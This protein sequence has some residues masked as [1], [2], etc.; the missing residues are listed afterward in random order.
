MSRRTT[1]GESRGLTFSCEQL[2]L[3][4]KP[5]ALYEGTFTVYGQDGETWGYVESTDCRMELLNR[6]FAGVQDMVAFRFRGERTVP[7]EEISGSIRIYS[8][9]GEYEIPFQV[10]VQQTEIMSS[11]G[12]IRNLNQFAMLARN[13]WEE[14]VKLFYAPDFAELLKGNDR[15][16]LEYYRGLRARSGNQQNVEAFLIACGRKQ[17]IQYSVKEEQ[18]TLTNPTETTV[19]SVTILKNGWGYQKL[20]A[21]TVGEFLYL[22]KE[23]LTEDDFLGNQCVLPLYAEP[24]RLHAGRNHGALRLIY[25][26]E[27][28]EMPVCVI[29]GEENGSFHAVNLERKHRI[30]ELT[31]RYLQY[32]MRKLPG[33][34]WL[35]EA[36]RIVGRLVAMNEQDVT[37]RLMQAQ[38]LITQGREHEGSWV[39]THAQELME[40]EQIEEPVLTAYYLY[41]T[42][43]V[44]QDREAKM[45]ATMQIEELYRQNRTS[46]KLAWLYLQLSAEY[47]RDNTAR[48]H[49]LARQF[50]YGCVSPIWYLESLITLSNNP[51]LLRKL[52][53]YEIQVLYFGAQNG[54]LGAE[55]RE[56]M[57]YLAGRRREYTPLLLKALMACFQQKADDRL[58]QEICAQLIKGART[59]SEAYPWYVLGVEKELRLTRLYEYYMLSMELSEEPEISRKAVMYFAWQSN[60]DYEHTAYLY[61]YVQKHREEYEELYTRYRER[62]EHFVVD[63]I[64]KKHINRHLAYLYQELLVPAMFSEQ[65]A[66]Q[67]TQLLFARQVTVEDSAISNVL[68]YRQDVSAPYNCSVVNGTAWVPV[69]QER[70]V[71]LLEDR[72]GNRY[73]S[74]IPFTV[75]RLMDPEPFV[76]LTA[77][78]LLKSRQAD[79]A[80][81]KYLWDRG[82]RQSQLTEET[83]ERGKRLLA[84][85]EI[86]EFVKGR[87]QMRLLQHYQ[88]MDART[89]LEDY[90]EKLDAGILDQASRA[91]VIKYLVKYGLM[92]RAGAWLSEYGTEG[93]DALTLSGWCSYAVDAGLT[94]EILLQAAVECFRGEAYEPAVLTY[95]SK[96]W[97]GTMEE[98]FAL[99]KR[100]QEAGVPSAA[101]CGRILL[102]SLLTGKRPAMESQLLQEYLTD[103]PEEEVVS[104]VLGRWSG[105]YLRGECEAEVFMIRRILVR[106]RD[107]YPVGMEEKLACLKYFALVGRPAEE[108]TQQ[109]Q[110]LFLKEMLNMGIRLNFMKE[111]RGCEEWTGMLADK[112]ILECIARPG[113]RVQLHYRLDQEK[114]LTE[115]M[116]MAPGGIF[117]KELLLFYGETCEYFFTVYEEGQMTNSELQTVKAGEIPEREGRYLLIQRL[118]Q[119]REQGDF[120]ALDQGL[121]TLYHKEYLSSRLF[122]MR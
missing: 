68:V 37:A 95:L 78:H 53:D 52:E 22:E 55:L 23:Q 86:S 75:E 76:E 25:G 116:L 101:V 117:Y 44:N 48:Y 30:A 70:D 112:T 28:I 111:L 18:L 40:S 110:E 73:A 107:E 58:L 45:R 57:V 119:Y 4:L 39:L 27:Y 3:F 102:R 115:D 46:W 51:T 17:A 65:T 7:G 103:E 2:E 66:L 96:H 32:R 38:L 11:Q 63:Q 42:T 64:L 100:C 109:M 14:A 99:L 92:D 43:L 114:E 104:A 122:T 24:E 47:Q 67:L 34:V 83:A 89:T 74:G 49:F 5:G 36:S 33:D 97:E 98:L 61:S 77:T 21:E 10:K 69:Y 35:E 79:I 90:L 19:L 8:N 118:L 31:E 6:E 72:E 50:T 20:R 71:I 82:R 94:D 80:W 87:V 16:Y 13:E 60:M 9:L 26:R 84:S 15:K 12:V 41:L 81:E 54:L 91:E 113:A 59:D 1:D 62:M 121:M 105:C 29:R 85:S 93:V 88:E 108:S 56:Q 120:T 106:F